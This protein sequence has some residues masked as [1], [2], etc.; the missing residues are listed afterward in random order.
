MNDDLLARANVAALLPRYDSGAEAWWSQYGPLLLGDEL[1]AAV[2]LTQYHPLTVHL[3]GGS[4]TYDF[5]H[6]LTNGTYVNVEVKGS[7]AQKGYR[8]PRAKLRA[9]AALRPFEMWYEVRCDGKGAFELERIGE[10]SEE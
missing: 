3:P 1:G 4:Y 10:W 6:I 9:A 7:K 5:Q 8:D 2:V